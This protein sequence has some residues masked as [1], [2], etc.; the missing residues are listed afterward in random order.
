MLIKGR[1]TKDIFPIH[2]IIELTPNLYN[3]TFN[4][5][6][7]ININVDKKFKNIPKFALHSKELNIKEIKLNDISLNDNYSIDIDNEL[8]ILEPLNIVNNQNIL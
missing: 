8:L 5:T 2:Y 4:G 3:F 7:K 6:V 1:L